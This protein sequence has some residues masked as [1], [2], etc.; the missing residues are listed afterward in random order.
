MD[1]LYILNLFRV[2]RNSGEIQGTVKYNCHKF[3]YVLKP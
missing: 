2:S 1:K 3:C